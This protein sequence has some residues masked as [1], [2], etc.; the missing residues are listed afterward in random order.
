RYRKERKLGEGTYAVVYEGK[1]PTELATSRQVA[2]KKIKVRQ[3]KDGLDVSALRE[4]KALQ[5][6]RHPHILEL[7]DVYAHKGNLNLVLEYLDSDLEQIIKDRSIVFTA[8]NIKSWMLM[9]LRGIEHCHRNWIVHRDMKPNNLLLSSSGQLKIADFGLARDYADLNAAGR[10]TSQV[11]T[12]WYRAPELLFGARDY[13]S[14]VD[15]WSVGCIFAELMLRTPY[16]P[17]DSEMQQLD[18]IFKALGTP[19]E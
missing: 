13:A 6:L 3:Q 2:I 9:T 4:I 10:M 8:A 15:M 12:L 7:L 16:L 17:G 18:L 1:S 14:A 11:V 19:T 5:E